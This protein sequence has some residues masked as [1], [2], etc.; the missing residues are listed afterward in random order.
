MT[1]PATQSDGNVT[2]V[3]VVIPTYNSGQWLKSTLEALEIA[4]SHTPWIAEVIVVDDGS[5]DNTAE[6][7]ERISGSFGYPLT[8][9]SQSNQGRYMARWVGA[10]AAAHPTM[11]LLDS[12]ILL[13]PDSLKHVDKVGLNAL[14]SNRPKAWNGH[15]ITDPSGSLVGHFWE[16]PTFVFWG[17]YLRNPAPTIITQENFNRVPKGTTFFICPTEVFIDAAR[18]HWPEENAALTNDDTKII[19][20]IVS[21]TELR[22]DPG[23]WALYRPRT[24][25]RA[26]IKHTFARGTTFVD[27]FAGVSW[28]M[29]AA[30][31]LLALSPILA[32]ATLLALVMNE[33]FIALSFVTLGLVAALTVPAIVAAYNRCPPKGIFSYFTYVFVFA[34]PY[35]LGILRGLFLHRSALV[36][37]RSGWSS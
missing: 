23:F 36:T 6:V 15:S 4:L 25:V 19:R 28:R 24:N 27:G 20:D 3:S 7:L 26:F 14:D 8:V 13:G 17:H 16:V 35:W 12:R 31:F 30:V 11:M 9:I 21:S 34:I 10:N 33:Q 5:T 29:N 1:P 22:I 2:S 37:T 18:A 32:I